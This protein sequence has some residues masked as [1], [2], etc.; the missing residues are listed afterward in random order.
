MSIAGFYEVPEHKVED[1][2]K[3]IAVTKNKVKGER[4]EIQVM[5]NQDIGIVAIKV[6]GHYFVIDRMESRMIDLAV[7]E[8]RAIAVAVQKEYEKKGVVVK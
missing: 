5:Q 3:R 6:D 8:N 1:I 7:Q 2:Q 4:Q